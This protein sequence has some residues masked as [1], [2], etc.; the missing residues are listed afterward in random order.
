MYT[1][2]DIYF[3]C[4]CYH[5]LCGVTIAFYLVCFVTSTMCFVTSTMWN[6]VRVVVFVS[7]V[8]I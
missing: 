4:A 3:V 8:P 2:F 6:C 1:E 7:C 5:Y